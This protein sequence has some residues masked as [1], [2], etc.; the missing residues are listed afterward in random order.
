M[1]NSAGVHKINGIE[2]LMEEEPSG[3]L[4]HR[5]H[6]LAKVEEKTTL[7]KLHNNEDQVVNDATRGLD[8]LAGVTVLNHADDATVLEVLENRNFVMYRKDGVGVAAEELFLKN[9]DGGVLF[10]A[11]DFSEVY[12]AGV[13]LTEGLENFVFSVENGMSLCA[14]ALH[15]D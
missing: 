2:H 5:A 13:A 6:G 3:V 9:F 1:Y 14:G 10:T 15:F 11:D 12:L 4:S 8:D 7:Y